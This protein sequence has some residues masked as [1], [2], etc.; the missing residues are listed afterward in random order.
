MNNIKKQEELIQSKRE[1][2]IYTQE[3]VAEITRKRLEELDK[4]SESYVI[5]SKE[6]AWDLFKE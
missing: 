1:K 5:N 2:R 6:F 3:E 4:A